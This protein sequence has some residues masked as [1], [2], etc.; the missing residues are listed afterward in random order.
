MERIQEAFLRKNLGTLWIQGDGRGQRMTEVSN[1]I[2][3]CTQSS[4]CVPGFV[5]GTGDISAIK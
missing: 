4:Y 5:L 1:C 3:K 2:H